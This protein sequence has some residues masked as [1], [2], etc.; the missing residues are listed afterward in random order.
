MSQLK[1]EKN[2]CS[3]ATWSC[4]AATAQI[5]WHLTLGWA[6]HVLRSSLSRP[7]VSNLLLSSASLKRK[8]DYNSEL[9]AAGEAFHNQGLRPDRHRTRRAG[10]G[11]ENAAADWSWQVWAAELIGWEFRV[12][13]G[14]TGTRTQIPT[15]Q[16]SHWW[17]ISGT[18]KQA[19]GKWKQDLRQ[20]KRK[21]CHTSLRR[22]FLKTH[23]LLQRYI[24]CCFISKS[25]K[26]RMHIHQWLWHT[27]HGRYYSTS[28][29]TVQCD[30][31]F[32]RMSYRSCFFCC[33]TSWQSSC[34]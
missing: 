3:D 24:C 4:R 17:L 11:L 9:S 5:L 26:L 13:W 30:L 2:K 12:G 28:C 22:S 27:A 19:S 7:H 31:H 25:S 8:L 20:P 21:R 18:S 1:T 34:C 16:Q 10:I 14:H 15:Y 6:G 33:R 23:Q 32:P 29:P